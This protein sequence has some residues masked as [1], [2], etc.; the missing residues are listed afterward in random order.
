MVH[1]SPW[2]RFYCSRGNTGSYIVFMFQNQQR[3]KD[4]WKVLNAKLAVKKT[5]R[6]AIS[7]LNLVISQTRNLEPVLEFCNLWI[8]HCLRECETA[9]SSE[10]FKLLS[11]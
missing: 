9:N 4:V 8:F 2:H 11:K 1:Q 3:T 10:G 5:R 7:Y 6:D